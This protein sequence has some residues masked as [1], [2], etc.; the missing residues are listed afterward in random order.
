ML[1]KKVRIANAV[2]PAKAGGRKFLN[3]PES[4]ACPGPDP[5]FAGMTF[6]GLNGSDCL[7]RGAQ[8][9]LHFLLLSP[10]GKGGSRGIFPGI[11]K[12]PHAPLC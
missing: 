4:G 6:K 3:K 10:F 8:K 11:L 5:G 9:S 2:T 12:S 7:L 1:T